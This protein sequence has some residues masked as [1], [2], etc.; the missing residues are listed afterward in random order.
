M[1]G[2]NFTA[3]LFQH[4][5]FVKNAAMSLCWVVTFWCLVEKNVCVCRDSDGGVFENTPNLLEIG[6]LRCQHVQ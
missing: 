4:A 3:V 6:L 1:H 2:E 5:R